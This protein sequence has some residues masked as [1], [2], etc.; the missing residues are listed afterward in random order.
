MSDENALKN[1]MMGAIPAELAAQVMNAEEEQK[2]S[3]GDA[4]GTNA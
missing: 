3:D 2:T 4:E 1:F